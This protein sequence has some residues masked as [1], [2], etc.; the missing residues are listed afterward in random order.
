MLGLR[1]RKMSERKSKK[2]REREIKK[3][4]ETIQR[5]NESGKVML[6]TGCDGRERRK[7]NSKKTE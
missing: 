6:E 4:M 5:E 3:M 7:M 2:N 1:E